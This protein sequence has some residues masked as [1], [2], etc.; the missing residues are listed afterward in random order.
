MELRELGVDAL[1]VTALDEIAWLF[2]IRGGD[3][4]P[5]SPTVKSYAYVS[6]NQLVLFVDSGKFVLN[7]SAI[8]S[9]LSE[10][11]TVHCKESTDLCIE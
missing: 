3:M 1:V 10:K 9:H 7:N 5:Y 11:N 4:A 8:R 2:N 6:Q